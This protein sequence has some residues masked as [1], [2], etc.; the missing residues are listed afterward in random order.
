M[1]LVLFAATPSVAVRPPGE[2]PPMDA[3]T[4][5]RF[6]G[7]YQDDVQIINK[8]RAPDMHR[9]QHCAHVALTLI[10]CRPV[11]SCMSLPAKPTKLN[12]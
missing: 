5:D 9:Q 2:R 3:Y 6:R 1:R 4:V 10:S 8:G 7:Y 12:C 11:C